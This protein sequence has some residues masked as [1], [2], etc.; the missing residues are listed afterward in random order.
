MLTITNPE[1]LQMLI[2][3]PGGLFPVRIPQENLLHL[4]IKCPKEWILAAKMNRGFRF[5]LAPLMANGLQTHGLVSA[6]FD[7]KDEPLTIWSPLFD[8]ELTVEINEL[9]SSDKFNVHFFDEHNRELLGCSATNKGAERFRAIAGTMHFAPFSFE[10]ARDLHTQLPDWFGVRTSADDDDALA[11][12][13]EEPLFPDDLYIQDARPDVNSYH[14]AKTSMHTMLERDD[15]GHFN[16]LDIVHALQRIFENNE[17]YLNPMRDDDGKEFLD[18]LV[19]TPKSVFLIQAKDSPNTEEILRRS[20]DRKKST[21]VSHL[22]K[23]VDQM[24]GSIA[25]TR[26]CTPLKI[27]TNCKHHEI[28]LSDREVIGLIIVKELFNAEF[29]IYSPPVMELFD[30]TGVPCFVLDYPEFH[31]YTLH[32]SD[33]DAFI[34]AL[35]QVFAVARKRGEFPRLRFGLNPSN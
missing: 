23:A 18:V 19:V 15:A 33:E 30:E 13:F 35:E 28:E 27:S 9:L 3:F 11:I 1:I 12:I 10:L 7:D 16:E 17:I 26:S 34:G 22:K 8:D 6:F 20:I 29:S 24:R 31:A 2:N 32:L 25:Y 5:Y 21:I 14:G 4:I